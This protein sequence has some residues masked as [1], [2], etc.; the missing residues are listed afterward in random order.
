[1]PLDQCK[2]TTMGLIFF[3][4]Q[5][6]FGPRGTSSAH[7]S[8]Y[9]A[10]FMEL[11]VA[12]FVPHSALLTVKSVNSV[13]ALDGFFH[14]RKLSV[15]F[16]QATFNYTVVFQVHTSQFVLVGNELNTAGN[17]AQWL[18]HFSICWGAWMP[19]MRFSWVHES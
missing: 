10:F 9:N 15:F 5:C 17:E 1:M 3:A 7:C 18:L 2:L 6:H 13:V 19:W 12:F 11:P 14:N 4:V 16:M 8:M